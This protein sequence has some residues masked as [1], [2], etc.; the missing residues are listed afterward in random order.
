[1]SMKK[2][3]VIPESQLSL[4]HV[5]WA[6]LTNK[7]AQLKGKKTNT[8]LIIPNAKQSSHKFLDKQTLLHLTYRDDY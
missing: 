4:S 7:T 3:E 8:C 5:D 6:G 2:A 1:M